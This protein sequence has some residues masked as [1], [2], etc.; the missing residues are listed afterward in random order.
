MMRVVHGPGGTARNIS[1][2]LT[3]HI[4]GKT[5]TAQVVSRR[6]NVSLNPRALPMHLRH[7][8][9]FVGYA[10]AENPTI[11]VAVVVEGGGFGASTAAPIARKILDTWVLGKLPEGVESVDAAT[12]PAATGTPPA[13]TTAA[14]TAPIVAAPSTAVRPATA[15]ASAPVLPPPPRVPAVTR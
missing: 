15:P 13:T 3:Y 1:G 7:R 5:G 2:G 9:L 8:A 6:G 11:A 12:S 10:P 4:A 14:T